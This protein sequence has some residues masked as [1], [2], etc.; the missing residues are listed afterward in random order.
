MGIWESGSGGGRLVW[1]CLIRLH[2]IRRE[3][4]GDDNALTWNSRS[5]SLSSLYTVSIACEGS[6]VEWKP[7]LVVWQSS[8]FRRLIKCERKDGTRVAKCISLITLIMCSDIRLGFV[9]ERVDY[10]GLAN[11]SQMIEYR[12]ERGYLGGVHLFYSNDCLWIGREKYVDLEDEWVM[13]K[14][15]A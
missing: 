15:W 9:E 6:F 4:F 5:L 12:V 8:S 11:Y 7:F 2:W 14:R 13:S 3:L 10:L 1:G